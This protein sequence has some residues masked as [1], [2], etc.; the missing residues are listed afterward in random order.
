MPIQRHFIDW[1]QP[2]LP[3]T[4]DYVIDRYANGR[5]LDL[6]NLVLVFTG[7]RASRR[8]MELLLEK[9]SEKW[10]AFTPPRM[11]TFQKF[12]EMLY[13]QQ[14]Q[15]ADDLTQL[16]VWKKALS[17]ISASELKA[18]L[19]S[20]PNDDAVP[21]WLSLCE[22]LRTQHNELAEDGMEFDEVFASLAKAGNREEAERWK[23]LRRIQ[24]EYLVQMD[25]LKLWDRQASRLIAV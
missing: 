5:E 14:N 18:A 8:F 22:S 4:A 19:P 21:S 23:A 24:S 20:I 2:A 7:R 12:P 17:S 3:A 16:L 13:R 6:R 10:P 1:N 11:T 25:N 9:A 15:L